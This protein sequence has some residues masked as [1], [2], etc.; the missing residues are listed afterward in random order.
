[1]CPA[2]LLGPRCNHDLGVLLRLPSVAT[3]TTDGTEI[4]YE[5]AV[6]SMLEAMGDHEFYCAAYST[7][8]QPH[9][10]GLLTTLIDGLRAKEQ[11]I[12]QAREAGENIDAMEEAR[13]ILHRLISCKNRRFKK[14]IQKVRTSH[15]EF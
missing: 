10:V 1:M 2:I 5:E 8:D 9:V 12:L 4:S 3:L 13:R 14:G 6:E 11:D 7:K 15:A